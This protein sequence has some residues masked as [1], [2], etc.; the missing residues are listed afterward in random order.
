MTI[1]E[2]D[3]VV[4]EF[5]AEGTAERLIDEGYPLRF[6]VLA[7]AFAETRPLAVAVMSVDPTVGVDLNAAIAYPFPMGMT[8]EELSVTPTAGVDEVR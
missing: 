2:R 3:E 5:T 1:P 6:A 8:I 4:V 7:V